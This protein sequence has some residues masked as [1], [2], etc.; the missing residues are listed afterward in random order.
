[1]A[2]EGA[3]RSRHLRLHAFIPRSRANGPGCRAV[4]WVQGCTLGCPGCFNPE[5]HDFRGGQ[6]V[7]VDELFERIRALQGTIEGITV[8]GGEPF[9]QRPA[10]LAL[11][12]RVRAETDLGVLVFTGY[13]WDEIQRFRETA[14]LL[15]CIDVL[16]AGRYDERL[17]LARDLRG[18]ANKTVHLLT[19][20]YGLHD[21][22][23]TP[24]SEVIIEPD[25]TVVISGIDPLRWQ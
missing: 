1:M 22:Q 13:T 24:V 7:G 11:L 8:S 19:P 10:L 15:Q 9:Q 3:R 20:R 2:A 12:Q 21:L 5:T 18:S 17:R 25:G 23:L 4:V 14:A 6:W 16:I